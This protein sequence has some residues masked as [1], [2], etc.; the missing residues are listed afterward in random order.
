MADK[1]NIAV[2]GSG[3]SGISSAFILSQK[4]NVSL[5]EKNNYIGG[6]TNTVET[7]DNVRVD[8]GFIVMNDKTYPNF[9]TFLDKLE[10]NRIKTDMSFG[11]CDKKKDFYYSTSSLNT[12]FAQR[13]NILNLDYLKF[14]Y[15]IFRF[16]KETKRFLTYGNNDLCIDQFLELNG[17]SKSFE[18]KYILPMASAIWSAPQDKIARFPMLS[19]ANFYNNHGLLSVTGQPQWY[20]VENGSSSYVDAFLKQFSGKV[21]KNKKAVKIKQNSDNPEIIFEDNEALKFDKIIV[22]AHADE[23]FKMLENPDSD[24]TRLL[25]PWTYSKNRVCLHTDLSFMPDNK[26]AWA[27]WNYMKEENADKNSP[28]CITYDMTKLQKLKSSKRFLVTLNPQREI[29]KD[30]L[31]KDIIY[32]HPIYTRETMA[33][34]DRL[35]MLNQK[36][37]NIF[38]CG[39][40]FGYGFHE[41]GIASAVKVCKIFGESL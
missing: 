7:D 41:D 21:Y 28:A 39:S 12:I 17:F 40:Y 9:T 36:D 24:Q 31:I 20:F 3:I 6:H 30:K 22:A 27:S 35:D 14:L 25:G 10:I 33:T 8:T 4:H 32:T 5:F 23:A 38:F 18:E 16:F 37:K 1:L 2:I 11:Y 34:Q 13:K 26:R 15:E 19:F 29:Q